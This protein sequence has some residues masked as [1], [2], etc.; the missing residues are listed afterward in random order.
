MRRFPLRV[1]PATVIACVALLVALGSTGY[2]AATLPRNSVGSSQ[3]KN[4]AV[5]NTKLATNAVTTSKVKNGSLLRSDFKS[6]QVPTGPRGPV[7]PPGP[8]GARGP[9]GPAG[10]SVSSSWALVSGAGSLIAGSPGVTVQHPST[11][12]YFVVFPSA[13]SG[14]AILATQAF[15]NTDGGPRGG[16]FVT[17]CGGGTDASTCTSSNTSSTVR[18]VVENNTNTTTADHAFY[19]AAV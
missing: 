11:G 16:I 15:R 17:I 7:G 5:T 9:T 14:H 6:G 19:V 1:S 12:I 10:P 3:L 4:G 8:A 18:V 2:A 13:V